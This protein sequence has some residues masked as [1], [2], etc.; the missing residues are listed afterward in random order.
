MD[1]NNYLGSFAQ[2]NVTFQTVVVQNTSYGDNF[3][4]VMIFTEKSLIA[5]TTALVDVE[6]SDTIKVAPVTIDDFATITKGILQSWLSDLFANGQTE[7]VYCVINGEDALTAE[8]QE[9]AYELLKA[10]AYFKTVCVPDT[11]TDPSTPDYSALDDARFIAL[12]PALA[13]LCLIDKAVL[14]GPVL[15]PLSTATPADYTIDPRYVAFKDKFIF[16]SYHQDITRNAALYAIGLALATNNTSG[17]PIG[18]SP[19]M[20]KSNNITSNN[21]K[22]AVRD[23]LKAAHI[24]TWK[25][26]GDNSTNVAAE[27]DKDLLGNT[28]GAIWICAYVAY[29]TKVAVAVMMTEP[30]FYKNASNYQGIL[31]TMQNILKTFSGRLDNIRITAP[32]FEDLPESASDRLVIQNAWEATYVDHLRRVDISGTLYIGEE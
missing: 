13:D 4:R 15:A 5:D 27:N 25:P 26:V 21:L 12:A 24:Q 28:L 30:N 18:N 3:K 32:T 7:E 29:M 2:E 14:S 17:T 10:Y 19:D 20:V 9:E 16:L 1:T 22:K 6:G 8:L 23:Q 11:T 31:A